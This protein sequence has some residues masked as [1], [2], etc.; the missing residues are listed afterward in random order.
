MKI[1]ASVTK[2][3]HQDRGRAVYSYLIFFLIHTLSSSPGKEVVMIAV[4][5]SKLDYNDILWDCSSGRI[6]FNMITKRHPLPVVFTMLVKICWIIVLLRVN[7][8]CKRVA[9]NFWGQGRFLEIRTQQLKTNK[10][11]KF[12]TVL[13]GKVTPKHNSTL[14]QKYVNTY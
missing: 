9:R 2:R 3:S 7:E 10:I 1:T 6:S 8:V 14:F 4:F 12:L 5:L 13:R 11:S